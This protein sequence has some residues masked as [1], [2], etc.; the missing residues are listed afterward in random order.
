MR[1]LGVMLVIMVVIYTHTLNGK[2][3]RLEQESCTENC[4]IVYGKLTG[5]STF[6]CLLSHL[7]FLVFPLGV[8]Y[9]SLF[10]W[11]RQHSGACR[12]SHDNICSS[13]DVPHPFITQL[14]TI[15]S[16]C[17]CLYLCFSIWLFL[18]PLIGHV[19]LVLPLH[20]WKQSRTAGHR[21]P[22]KGS[23]QVEGHFLNGERLR[24]L[25]FDEDWCP[26]QEFGRRINDLFLHL[27]TV[28]R[29]FSFLEG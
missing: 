7:S 21:P 2:R 22:F 16:L 29:R 11:G 18:F 8:C 10:V 9:N 13:E 28:R 24:K 25:Q 6:C 27:F 19:D 23:S 3:V 12:D 1:V 26:T 14:R 4:R 17:V 15:M 20:L 5:F